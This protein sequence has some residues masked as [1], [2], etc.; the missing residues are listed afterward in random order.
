[1]RGEIVHDV[2]AS[3]AHNQS[4][5]VAGPQFQFTISVRSELDKLFLAAIFK[6]QRIKAISP[7]FVTATQICL[8]DREQAAE[9]A[10]A[11]A[12]GQRAPAIRQLEVRILVASRAMEP[13][14]QRHDD[15]ALAVGRPS[16]QSCV[17]LSKAV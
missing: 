6:A 1:S 3:P 7:S 11:A 2:D 9:S 4:H 12:A 17:A 10:L 14:G 15:Q 5:L 13:S 8:N 16:Y